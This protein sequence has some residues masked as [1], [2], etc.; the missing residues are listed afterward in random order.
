MLVRRDRDTI[1][2]LTAT[3]DR[4]PVLVPHLDGEVQ[5]LQGLA[6][7]AEHLLG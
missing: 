1:S 2:R 5:D 6:R 3:V 7:I 4:E